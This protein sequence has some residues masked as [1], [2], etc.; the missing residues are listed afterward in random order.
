MIKRAEIY[1]LTLVLAL[2]SGPAWAAS[3]YQYVVDATNR[4]IELS[5]QS[6]SP[7]ADVLAKASAEACH[8]LTGLLKDPEFRKDL[9][10]MDQRAPKTH[11]ERA[12][13]KRDLALFVGAFL[14]T[15]EE[16][17]KKAGLKKEAVKQILWSAGMLQ[18]ALDDELDLTRIITAIDKFRVEVCEAAKG[19]EQAQEETKRRGILRKWAFRIGGVALIV[20][21]L[22]AAALTSPVA[23]GSVA[24]GTVVMSWSE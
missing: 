19:I 18:E 17:L 15:E 1:L 23:V 21:D 13:L 4:I 3:K 7:S 10:K 20:V 5:S 11:E 6:M 16:A 12:K 2:V 22:T 8:A 24:I 14:R 9:D